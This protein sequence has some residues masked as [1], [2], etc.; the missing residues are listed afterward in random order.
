M[1][2]V[3][4]SASMALSWLVRRKEVLRAFLFVIG[5]WE[6]ETLSSVVLLRCNYRLFGLEFRVG[7][8]G[9]SFVLLDVY[10]RFGVCALG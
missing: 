3:D 7:K 2:K 10:L 5:V 1:R 6:V 4:G 9:L 8:H